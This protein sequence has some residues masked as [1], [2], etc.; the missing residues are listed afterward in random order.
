MKKNWLMMAAALLAVAPMCAQQAPGTFSVTP[1]VGLTISNFTNDMPVAVAYAVAPT[2]AMPAGELTEVTPGNMP[3]L[4]AIGFNHPKSKVGFTVGAEAQYQFTKVFGLSL[5]AFYTQQGAKYD[6]KGYTFD[7]DGV[8][9]SINNDLNAHYDC[10]TVPVLANAYV[11][12]GLAVK[13][14][15]QPEFAV[16]KKTKGDV[17]ISYQGQS[18]TASQVE[19]SSLRSFALSLPVGLS[20][21]FCHLVADVRYNIGLTNLYKGYDSWEAQEGPSSR[22]S[23]CSVTLGYKFQL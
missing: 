9:V 3:I 18:A 13:A 20:Y 11:W 6:T 22:N 4:G 2:G 23:T 17:T 14:G 5:G 21:E 8:H 12:K 1:K 16:N 7:I 10:I 19:A 15:L